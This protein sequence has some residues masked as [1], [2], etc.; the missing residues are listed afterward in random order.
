MLSGSVHVVAMGQSLIH[1][2]AESPFVHTHQALW[3][4]WL[5][6]AWCL[7]FDM[8]PFPFLLVVSLKWVSW[9]QTEMQS[10][11]FFVKQRFLQQLHHF[12]ALPGIAR[13]PQLSTAFSKLALFVFNVSHPSKHK[14]ILS[15]ILISVS[16]ITGDIEHVFACV[17]T[18]YL[19]SLDTRLFK[20]LSLDDHS[21]Y[22]L[23]Q[24]KILVI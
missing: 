4:F 6:S 7:G 9:H 18:I 5:Q 15:L 3:G 2:R 14:V 1:F 12:T 23:F 13:G 21:L 16:L 8:R 17:L 22:P 19:S 24:E 10:L 11:T 20:S